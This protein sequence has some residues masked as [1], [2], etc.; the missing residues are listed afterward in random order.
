MTSKINPTT[1]DITYPIAGQD[2]DTQGFRNNFASTQ[3]NFLIASSEISELQS[4][5]ASA[6][7]F[8]TAPFSG[9][10]TGTT[11][12]LA[13]GSSSVVVNALASFSNNNQIFV[14]TVTNLYRGAPIV[15]TPGGTAT[16]T[17]TATTA[18][19]ANTVTSAQ[20]LT[21]GGNVWQVTGNTF[22]PTFAN[23]SANTNP[24]WTANTTFNYGFVTFGGNTFRIL[25]NAFG[26]T[27]STVLSTNRVVF[28]FTGFTAVTNL[29][30]GSNF[31]I[32]T[33]TIGNLTVGQTY[34]ITDIPTSNLIT[35]GGLPNTSNSIQLSNSTGT[36]PVTVSSA[37]F[38]VC[39][40][41]NTWV[42]VPM[43]SWTS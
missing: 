24:A 3:T 16:Q 22:A 2:N 7:A 30:V 9:T 38:Y 32:N 25:S 14:T 37:Y 4:Q 18:W 6:A 11:G 23:I 34:Y 35:V 41:T 12:Q 13:Y 31:T 29:G 1:I 33:N 10:S 28:A 36:I 43:S 17:L 5:A 42:R 8:T 40:A 21:N 15:V 26:A 20:Q 39:T 27:F 19:T